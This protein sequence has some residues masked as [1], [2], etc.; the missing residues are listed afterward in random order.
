LKS[1]QFT[2]NIIVILGPTATGKT[3]F[4][5]ELAARINGEIISA[6]SR[7]VYRGMN[8]GTGKDYNDYIVA[9]K[10]IPYHLIDLHDPGYKYNVYEFQRDFIQ[11]FNSILFSQHVPVLCGGTGLYIEAVTRA[12]KL[13]PVPVNEKL[14]EELAG[15]S[16]K[17]LEN[18]LSSYRKL[19]NKTDTDT[20]ARAVRAIEIEEYILRHPELAHLLPEIRPVYFGIHCD[21]FIRR[22]RITERL[23]ERLKEGMVDEVKG[24]LDEGIEPDDLAYYGLEYKYITHYLQGKTSY[25][26]MVNSLNIAIHQFA[27]RQMTWFRKMERG[28]IKIHWIDI[29]LPLEEK[30]EIVLNTMALS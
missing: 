16:L 24:L 5:A 26:E 23:H 6:D 9:D 19:H 2:L 25:E 22:Q 8:L 10:V 14:R 18:T 1:T 28:G 4:A 11:A 13:I 21:R 27:K 7:Q 12:Y 17:E 29:Q 3:R 30:V 20:I 15:K